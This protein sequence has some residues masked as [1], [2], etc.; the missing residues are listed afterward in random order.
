MKRERSRVLMVVLL[1]ASLTMMLGGCAKKCVKV[2]EGV[3]P[4]MAAPMAKSGGTGEGSLAERGV[5]KDAGAVLEGRTSAPMLPVYFDFDKSNI[6]KDMQGRAE[7][8][9]A[10]LKGNAGMRIQVE[11]NCDER[12]TNEYNMALGERRAQSAK[13]YLVHL[14]V[15]DSRIDTVSYGEEKPL[16]YGHDEL[17][18]SQNRRDDFVINR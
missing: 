9:A 14:G 17:S 18:W 6:R 13:K 1:A 16:N 3:E 5:E 11:G 4:V 2:G 10:F 7:A 15:E 12:G 8:N